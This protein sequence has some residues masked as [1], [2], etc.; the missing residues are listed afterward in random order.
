M[1][2]Y[3]KNSSMEIPSAEA[4]ER[5]AVMRFVLGVCRLLLYGFERRVVREE[6]VGRK[7]CGWW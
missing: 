7:A 1:Q 6:A 4:L 3:E 2:L 5:H